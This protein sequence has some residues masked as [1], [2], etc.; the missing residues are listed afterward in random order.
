M[1]NRSAYAVREQ[2][3]GETEA[4]LMD[5]PDAIALRFDRARLL[6]ELGRNEEAKQAYLDILTRDPAHFGAL[7]NLGVLLHAAGF[8]TAARTVYAE[9]VNQH[10]ENPKGH[11]N[12]ANALLDND[13]LPTAR[14]HYEIALRLAPDL[15]E[16]HQGLTKLFTLMGDEERALLHRHMGFQRQPVITLPYRGKQ[17]PLPVLLIISAAGGNIPVRQFLDERVFLVSVIVAEFYDA[18]IMLPPHRLVINAIGD[19]ELCKA[20]LEAAEKIIARSAAP[21]INRPRAIL[22]TGRVMNATRL[23]S[24]EHLV[25]PKAATMPRALLAEPDALSTLAGRGFAFP[26]LLRTPGYHTGHY[27]IRVENAEELAASLTKLPGAEL[28]VLQYLDARGADQK[29]RKYRVMM[30]DQQLYPVHAAISHQWKVHYFSAE[31]ADHPAHRAEDAAFLEDMPGAIGPKAMTVLERIR[32]ALRLDYGGIDF[33][34]NPDG[35]VIL[36]EANATMI[37]TPPETGDRWTYRRAPIERIFDAIR[38]MFVEK[39]ENARAIVS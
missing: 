36:F 15:A 35:D 19:A 39:A 31:M 32:D 33:G 2:A 23:A 26:F 4:R 18:S 3:L 14:A 29:I 16:A 24:I 25:T 12:F 8:R 28:T 34:L 20:G 1:I 22:A 38:K 13:D 6:T 10:P 7:N 21:V 5:D 9:A 30:I 17:M 27:F 11:L 37:V